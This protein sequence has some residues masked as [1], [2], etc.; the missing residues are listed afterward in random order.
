L[1]TAVSTLDI[2]VSDL[3]YGVEQN[4]GRFVQNKAYW[5]V[6]DSAEIVFNVRTTLKAVD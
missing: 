4:K 2:A 6:V 3:L 1:D 5:S